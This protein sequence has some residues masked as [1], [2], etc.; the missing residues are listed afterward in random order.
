MV[1]LL[2]SRPH[3]GRSGFR[4]LNSLALNF[5]TLFKR[6]CQDTPHGRSTPEK[7]LQS[8]M[9]AD[10]YRHVRVMQCLDRVMGD[11][12][13]TIFVADEVAL[14]IGERQR[15]VCD[16]LALR[17]SSEGHCIPVVIELKSARQMKRLIEQVNTYADVMLQQSKAF[18]AL[19]SAILGEPI[20]FTAAPEQWIVWPRAGDDE[21]PRMTD[22]A[23]HGI[24]V[25]GYEQLNPEYRFRIGP[26]P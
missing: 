23:F 14:P 19:Y 3:L 16:V 10:A 18:K 20:G 12:M 1:G 13:T 25:I 8:W 21:D 15:V 17:K 26:H 5:N 9:T 11:T 7:P 6:H 24:R 22:L 2:P 4:N